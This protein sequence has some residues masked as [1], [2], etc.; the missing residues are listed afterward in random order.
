MVASDATWKVLVASVPLG[1]P[2]GA[3]TARDGVASGDAASGYEREITGLFRALQARGVQPPLWLTTDVHVATGFRHRPLPE[4]PDWVVTE[5]VTGPLNAGLF[6]QRQ[7]DPSFRPERTFF[8]GPQDAGAVASFEDAV[9]WFNFGLL[10]VHGSGR[11]AIAVLNGNGQTVYRTSMA[12]PG[13]A[14]ALPAR[15]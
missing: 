12:A 11:L 7:V 6:P 13:A 8:W 3:A 9:G 14:P 10:E 4:H 2:T 15:R 5:V 1:I